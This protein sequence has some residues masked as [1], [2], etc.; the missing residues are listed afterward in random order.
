MWEL[1]HI[2]TWTRYIVGTYA[3]IEDAETEVR[4]RYGYAAVR[5]EP[6]TAGVLACMIYSE[7]YITLKLYP[8]SE[9]KAV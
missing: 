2:S 8:V 9:L 5:F 4:A 7:E 6:D 1:E 3:S